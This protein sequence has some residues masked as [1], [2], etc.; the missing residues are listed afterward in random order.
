M[1]KNYQW[2]LIYVRVILMFNYPICSSLNANIACKTQ[3]NFRSKCAEANIYVL[4]KSMS[5]NVIKFI[6]RFRIIFTDLR[7]MSKNKLKKCPKLEKKHMFHFWN[8]ISTTNWRPVQ[9]PK[10][11]NFDLFKTI[12]A[13][14]LKCPGKKR[15]E[16]K[17]AGSERYRLKKLALH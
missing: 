13:K 5:R 14:N 6:F 16:G 2:Q 11:R 15:H 3:Q 8:P 10:Y 1:H 4:K 17:G 12:S 9:H 7:T